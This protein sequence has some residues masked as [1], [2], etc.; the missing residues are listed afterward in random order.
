MIGP[1][2]PPLIGQVTQM[3]ARLREQGLVARWLKELIFCVIP[4]QSWQPDEAVWIQGAHE[5]YVTCLINR[6][7]GIPHIRL[8]YVFIYI[9]LPIVIL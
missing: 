5:V 7:L 9:V 6:S 4:H 3:H 2:A 1:P 8:T